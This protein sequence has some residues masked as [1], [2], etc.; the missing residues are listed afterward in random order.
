MM[1]ECKNMLKSTFCI[2]LYLWNSRTDKTNLSSRKHICV[3]F[4]WNEIVEIDIKEE[5]LGGGVVE[6]Y[7][8]W[9]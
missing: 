4:A 7:V 6:C 1:G 3:G 5:N 8:S 2:V 9:V